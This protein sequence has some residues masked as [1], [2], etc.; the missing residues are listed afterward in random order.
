MHE[1]RKVHWTG[2]LRLLSYVKGAPGKGLVYKRNDHIK[3]MAYS[4]SGYA[5]DQGDRKSTSDF[6]LM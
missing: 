4:D 1:P 2:A 5:G 3:V 6:V